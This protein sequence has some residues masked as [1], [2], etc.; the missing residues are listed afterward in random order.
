MTGL[1]FLPWSCMGVLP[2]SEV[3]NDLL[4]LRRQEKNPKI[5]KNACM[6]VFFYYV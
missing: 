4:S 6:L 2:D 1:L 3:L 5:E